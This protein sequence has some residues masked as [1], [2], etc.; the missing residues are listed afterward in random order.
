MNYNIIS[1]GSQGNAIVLN[2]IILLDCGVPFRDLK[3]VY[4][5]L[6]IVLLTH[7]HGDHFN[8]TT[9][10]KLAAERPTLRFACCSWLFR[11]LMQCG[12]SIHN[13]D[14]LQIGKIYDYTAFQ[15]SPVQLYHDVYNAGWRVFQNAE[16]AIYMTDT[17][18]LEGITAKNYDLYLIEANYITEELEERIRSKE[19]AG[20]YVY[21][22]RVRNVHLSKE[23]A[24]EWLYHNM[25][26]N[27]EAIYI[28]Q[29]IEKGE[30]DEG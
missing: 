9:I 24:D 7:I 12:V 2:K 19:A 16:K 13:I 23:K 22:Y 6:K 17:V 1:T 28:H 30:N 3:G 15:I 18:T 14:V 8:K 11:E 4:K 20:E 27:S 26:E 21:E 25:G 5:D 10:R 29:H